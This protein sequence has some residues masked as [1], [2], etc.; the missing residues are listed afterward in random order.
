MFTAPSP[1]TADEV[2]A[3]LDSPALPEV[4]RRELSA[5]LDSR[6]RHVTNPRG[7]GSRE[8]TPIAPP[9]RQ[10]TE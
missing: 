7:A 8:P 3:T 1:P 9:V 6:L 4:F 5:I 10:A 2:R